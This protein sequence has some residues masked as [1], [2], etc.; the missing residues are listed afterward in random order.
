MYNNEWIGS[1]NIYN[2]EFRH[3]KQNKLWLTATIGV[4]NS[5]KKE[6]MFLSIKCINEKMCL[7]LQNVIQNKDFIKVIGKID[8]YTTGDKQY[9]SILVDKLFHFGQTQAK[10]APPLAYS[11]RTKD[12][13]PQ[14][15][16]TVD[17][18]DDSVP[19]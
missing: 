10:N 2:I 16:A 6:T 5:F 4:Y 8:L 13:M 12:G 11:V 17:D 7:E 1:G 19:F 14:D 18:T 9:Y 15:V 3:T